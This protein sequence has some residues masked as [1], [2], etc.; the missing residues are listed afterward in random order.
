MPTVLHCTCNDIRCQYHA[1]LPGSIHHGKL[2]QVVKA[3]GL[4]SLVFAPLPDLGLETAF[5]GVNRA[6]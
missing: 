1:I 2:V 3:A 4:G 5:D 6:P